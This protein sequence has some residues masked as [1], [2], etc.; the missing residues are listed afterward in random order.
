MNFL[1]LLQ[2]SIQPS[3]EGGIRSSRA[4][5]P[6]KSLSGRTHKVLPSSTSSFL[7]P[8]ILEHLKLDNDFSTEFPH[9]FIFGLPIT[10]L[11]WFQAT[12]SIFHPRQQQ[13]SPCSVCVRQ[14]TLQVSFLLFSPLKSNQKCIHI[15]KRFRGFFI[16]FWNW[17]QHQNMSIPS[18]SLGSLLVNSTSSLTA[19][20]SIPW[21]SITGF[22]FHHFQIVHNY[23]WKHGL[24]LKHL[25]RFRFLPEQKETG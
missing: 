7:F 23:Q 25:S 9:Y 19:V 3:L 24:H 16:I 18:W 2:T 12:A 8:P 15:S 1:G 21:H 14:I 13:L 5:P 10:S 17:S 11:R 20:E 22:C 6:P 4:Q